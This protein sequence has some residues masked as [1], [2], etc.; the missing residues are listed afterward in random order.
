MAAAATASDLVM[1][2]SNHHSHCKTIFRQPNSSSI[3]RGNGSL[4]Y[5]IIYLSTRNYSL[6]NQ[7]SL[8]RSC[9]LPSCKKGVNSSGFWSITK[10][11]FC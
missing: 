4:P 3:P 9:N 2:F 6:R 7:A 8:R 1:F 10:Q 5:R 11:Y